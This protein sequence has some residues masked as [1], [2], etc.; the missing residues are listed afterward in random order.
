MHRVFQSVVCN[1]DL[2]SA[3]VVMDVLANANRQP[4]LVLTYSVSRD[5]PTQRRV[6]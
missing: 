5:W 2:G 6:P 1:E 3:T 4:V